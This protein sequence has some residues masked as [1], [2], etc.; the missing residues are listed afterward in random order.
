[1]LNEDKICPKCQKSGHFNYFETPDETG[2]TAMFKH[3]T[4]KTVS[5]I[6]LMGGTRMVAEEI[7]CFL[8]QEDLDK[9]DWF[10]EW[11]EERKKILEEEYKKREEE[12]RK[13]FA[14]DYVKK[15]KEEEDKEDF[16]RDY[17]KWVEEE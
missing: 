14:E 11:F 9:C 10:K 16:E 1:M 15:L 2:V 4:G 3:K 6:L 13:K 5:V 12:D 17:I 7:K 8:K